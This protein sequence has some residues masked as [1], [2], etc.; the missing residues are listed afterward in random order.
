MPARPVRPRDA[1]SLII[2]DRQAGGPRVLLGRR[3]KQHRSFPD[4]F[5]FPGGTLDAADR[6]IEPLTELTHEQ[7]ARLPG[8]PAQSRALA[9]AAVRETFEETGLVFGERDGE[10][11]FRPALD[12]LAVVARAITPPQSPRRFHARFFIA[13]A[14][15]ASGTLR[16]NGE[17][18]DLDWIP[19]EKALHLPII[20]VTEF[21]LGHVLALERGEIPPLGPLPLFHYRGGRARIRHG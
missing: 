6:T 5:V 7:A 21:V 11:S 18:L 3:A 19:I 4:V 17:L 16:G 2:V 8:K 15:D 20:D 14:E 1:A 10:D 13:D 12:R 9:V